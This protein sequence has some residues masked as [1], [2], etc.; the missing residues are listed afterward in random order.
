MVP[1]LGAL[2]PAIMRSRVDFPQPDG[3]TR[4]TKLPGATSKLTAASAS[5]P[6]AKVFAA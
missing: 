3:P 4:L 2:K 1:L 6:D 5:V